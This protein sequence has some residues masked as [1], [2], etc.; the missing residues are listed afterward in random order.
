MRPTAPPFRTVRV[1]ELRHLELCERALARAYIVQARL[2]A[3]DRAGL[4]QIAARHLANSV[5]LAERAAAF[6]ARP[7]ERADDEDWLRGRLDD[8][9]TLVWAEHT[10]LA[11]Y[12]HHLLDHDEETA[13]LLM[14]HVLPAHR[15]A[16][17]FLER[18]STVAQLSEL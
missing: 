5:R 4:Q 3:H 13:R 7:E 15:D 8:R 2:D 12:H 9:R 16:L 1:G 14:E 6:G 11:T 18:D 17:A 10:A